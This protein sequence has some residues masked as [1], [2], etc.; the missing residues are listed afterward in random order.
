MQ[1]EKTGKTIQS[2]HRALDILEYLVFSGQGKRLSEISKACGLNKTTA[3]H[4]IKT[5]EMRGYLEQS[6]DTLRY[7]HGGMLYQ[8]AT[9]VYQNI[10]I[11]AY[12]TPAMQK[13]YQTYN[14]TV[15]LYLYQ[16]YNSQT[17]WQAVCIHA[18]ES[19][20]S[21]HVSI[22]VGTWYPLVN[23]AIG[24][25]YLSAMNQ[26]DLQQY[27]SSEKNFSAKQADELKEALVQIRNTHC[28]VEQ[29]EYEDGITNIAAPIYKWSGRFLAALCVSIPSHRAAQLIE[30]VTKDVVRCAEQLTAMNI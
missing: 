6:P 7:K 28:C 12:Y 2:I 11:I 19:T 24:R 5:L 20:A 10:D 15:T 14:E 13:L 4:I 9:K 30:P 1:E 25:L 16:H 26:E 29:N 22:P 23:T 3:F 8:I 17:D 21:I 27:L 18:L